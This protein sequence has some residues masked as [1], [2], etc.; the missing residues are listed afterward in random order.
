MTRAEAEIQAYKDAIA[1]SRKVFGRN[2]D[3]MW[4]LKIL[5]E[6]INENLAA[7]PKGAE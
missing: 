5:Q 1:D 2:K 4:V 6:K 7:I 3:R